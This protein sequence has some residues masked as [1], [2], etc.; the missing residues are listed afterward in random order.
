[1]LHNHVAQFGIAQSVSELSNR[2]R[3][4][5]FGHDATPDQVLATVE[6]T[7]GGMIREALSHQDGPL[8]GACERAGEFLRGWWGEPPAPPF[9]ATEYTE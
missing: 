5:C 6:A 4:L 7:I 3:S 1:M 9:A 2:D 8:A